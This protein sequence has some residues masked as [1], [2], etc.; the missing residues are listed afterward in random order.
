M[1][2]KHMLLEGY[3]DYDKPSDNFPCKDF[4]GVIGI[5]C[6]GCKAFNYT[7]APN[8]LALSNS[9]SIVEELDDFV[10][11]NLD[12]YDEQIRSKSIKKWND[13]CRTKLKEVYEE[14]EQIDN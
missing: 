13:I 8:E 4:K 9:M 10:A 2:M 1:R 12:M 14:L 3:C 6:I 5:H 7:I 11:I